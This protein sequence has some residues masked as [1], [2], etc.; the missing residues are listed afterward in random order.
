MNSDLLQIC[1]L[2]VR[3][4]MQPSEIETLLSQSLEPELPVPKIVLCFGENRPLN[5]KLS[6]SLRSHFDQI[7]KLIETRCFVAPQSLRSVWSHGSHQGKNVGS[8]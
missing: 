5:E 2:E 1:A 3:A 8:R 7:R 4:T 6:G